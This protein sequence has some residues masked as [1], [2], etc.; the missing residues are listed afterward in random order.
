[1]VGQVALVVVAVVILVEVEALAL[2]GKAILVA[3]AQVA[4]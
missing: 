1:M 2:L 3:L 4:Q